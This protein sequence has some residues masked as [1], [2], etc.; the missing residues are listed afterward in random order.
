MNSF[1]KQIRILFDLQ[2]TQSGSSKK[3]GVG[4]YS[5]SLFSSI[6]Q[7][8][9]P[10]NIYTLISDEFSDID[11]FKELS[12]DFS[13]TLRLPKFPLW[14]SERNYLGGYRD[15]MDG[16]AYCAAIH[17]LNPD[18]IYVSHIFEGFQERIAIPNPKLKA[19]GQIF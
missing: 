14:K 15:S 7:M 3:R 19:P 5:S 11:M 9:L 1:E 8:C 16:I 4:N 12:L 10:Q 6:S 13:H 2:A 17:S 18:V